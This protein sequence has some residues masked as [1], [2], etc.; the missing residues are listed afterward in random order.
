MNVK[1]FICAFLSFALLTSCNSSRQISKSKLDGTWYVK[2]ANVFKSVIEPKKTLSFNFD[3]G[4]LSVKLDVNSCGTKIKT[5]KKKIIFGDQLA[6]TKAC[7]DHPLSSK[8]VSALTGE[9]S[10][11]IEG[12][13]LLIFNDE[14]KILLSS[15]EEKKPE[16]LDTKTLLGKSYLITSYQDI[17]SGTTYQNEEKVMISFNEEIINLKLNVNNCS[18][19]V[20][21]NLNSFDLTYLFACTKMCCDSENSNRIKNL[22]KGSFQIYEGENKS[23]K[24]VGTESSFS[25]KEVE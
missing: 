12:K 24:L 25:L 21:Y 2:E 20:V 8:I 19:N 13:D 1:L 18:S 15:E 14:N 23:V 6:C 9:F 5:T 17:N 10:Y 3:K 11:K 4:M 16:V 22:L 7:C